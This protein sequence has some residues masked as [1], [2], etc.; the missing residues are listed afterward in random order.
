MYLISHAHRFIFV[1]NPKSGGTSVFQALR[2]HADWVCRQ[3]E[4][5]YLRLRA[6]LLFRESYQLSLFQPHV[7]ARRLRR[8]LPTTVWDDFYKFGIVRHPCGWL[9][10]YWKYVRQRPK[11]P[12]YQH[13]APFDDFRKLVE[14]LD[15]R[16]LPIR[17]QSYYLTDDSGHILVDRVGHLERIQEDFT[18]IRNKIGL[19]EVELQHHN[20]TGNRRETWQ[21]VYDD[22]MRERVGRFL[23]RDFEIF[24]YDPFRDSPTQNATDYR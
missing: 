20:R 6:A 1:H 12:E 16:A 9:W 13:F 7:P 2:Q 22:Y 3:P 8:K 19:P 5:T 14:A 10:S 11:H 23:R 18:A 4:K 17:P 15:V 24:G 21:M